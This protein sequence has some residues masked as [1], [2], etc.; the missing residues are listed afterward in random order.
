MTEYT[1][2]EL[3]EQN[4][5]LWVAVR[6]AGD[7]GRYYQL[8]LKKAEQRELAAVH[9]ANNIAQK[10]EAAEAEL[11]LADDHWPAAGPG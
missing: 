5:R 1:R 2:E 4:R 3:E 10:L 9:A 6:R 7:L 11:K 8:E